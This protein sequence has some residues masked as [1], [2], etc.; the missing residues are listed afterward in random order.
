MKLAEKKKLHD[1]SV[2]RECGAESTQNSA[3]PRGSVRRASGFV[4][5]GDTEAMTQLEKHD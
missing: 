2:S 4:L 5:V 1:S 3:H